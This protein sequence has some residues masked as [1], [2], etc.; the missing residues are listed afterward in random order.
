MIWRKA[1]PTTTNRK[2]PSSSGPTVVAFLS[3]CGAHASSEHGS[4][5]QPQVERSSCSCASG[6]ERERVS[7]RSRAGRG[8]T[9]LLWVASVPRFRMCESNFSFDFFILRCDE[10]GCRTAG[11]AP[12]ASERRL[13][14][15]KERKAVAAHHFGGGRAGGGLAA[16]RCTC[17]RT[18]APR[19]SC[20]AQGS[21]K[22]AEQPKRQP[23][24]SLPKQSWRLKAFPRPAGG[25]ALSQRGHRR[26]GGRMSRRTAPGTKV[27]T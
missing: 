23:T 17:A 5:E 11:A 19:L 6:A 26:G 16:A 15:R 9:V 8:R 3:L 27:H 4:R 1:E 7:A 2:K 13:L 24:G 10:P 20:R 25:G 14:L 22:G 12:A 18:A 21:K